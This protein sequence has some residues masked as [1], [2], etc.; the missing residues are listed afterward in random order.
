MLIEQTL[1][2][3]DAMKLGA[4]ADACRHQLRTGEAAAL[5]FEERFGLLADAEWTAREQRKLDRRLR[6]AK[7]RHARHPR[8]RRL[9]PPP[10]GSTASRS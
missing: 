5:G 4:M 10:A 2:K 9:H 7:L 3:L 6:A 1:D 8:G